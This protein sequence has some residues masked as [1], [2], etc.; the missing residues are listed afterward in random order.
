VR[1]DVRD[2]CVSI[3]GA[4]RWYAGVVT[5]GLV[6]NSE[7]LQVDLEATYKA[8]FQ[9]DGQMRRPGHAPDQRESTCQTSN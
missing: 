3:E 4:Y 9:A 1:N 5:V 2:E 7:N 6:R 8:P